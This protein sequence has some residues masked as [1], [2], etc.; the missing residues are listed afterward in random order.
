MTLFPFLSRAQADV[1]RVTPSVA[2]LCK[3]RDAID[4]ELHRR[5]VAS[6][7]AIDPFIRPGTSS[8]TIVSLDGSAVLVAFF[9]DNDCRAA[10]S[11]SGPRFPSY[12]GVDIA[13]GERDRWFQQERIVPLDVYE[14][15]PSAIAEWRAANE[16]ARAA[17]HEASERRRYEELKA[18]FEA[19]V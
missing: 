3:R 15:G 11:A 14:R 8:V 13:G 10:R 5:A 12:G 1:E 18:K 9:S 16:A 19:G 2:E 7:P 4:A 17:E 6:A